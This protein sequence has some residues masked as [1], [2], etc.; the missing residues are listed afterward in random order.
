MPDTEVI[1]IGGGIAGAS[2]AYHLA[3]LGRNVALLE[4]GD[5]ASEASGVN[6]GGIGALGWGNLPNLQSYLTM[7]SLQIFKH[8]Q[9]ELGYDSRIPRIRR[10]AGHPDGGTVRLLPGQRARA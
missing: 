5:I 2:T 9:L 10:P 8:M 1:V 6:A 4:R 3:E 7:G